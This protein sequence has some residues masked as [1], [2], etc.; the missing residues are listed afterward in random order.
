MANFPDLSS[1]QAMQLLNKLKGEGYVKGHGKKKKGDPAPVFTYVNE[2]EK[3]RKN[4]FRPE[5]EIDHLVS[6]S[7][8]S[9]GCG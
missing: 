6:F 7:F 9:L 2:E 5:R 4:Y 3:V 8:R 1:T